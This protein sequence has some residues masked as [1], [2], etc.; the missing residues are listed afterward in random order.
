M[1]ILLYNPLQSQ[2]L[3]GGEIV[4]LPTSDFFDK[5]Y[6]VN[7]YYEN[8]NDIKDSVQ[9]FHGTS[10]NPV[11]LLKISEQQVFNNLYRNV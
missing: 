10:P 3:V 2:S 9:V 11:F 5:D 8:Q 4:V 1:S 6:N 7:L